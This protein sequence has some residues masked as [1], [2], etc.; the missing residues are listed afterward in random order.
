MAR[1][2]LWLAAFAALATAPG[3][4]TELPAREQ[5]AEPAPARHIA[6]VRFNADECG[7]VS[8]A[9]TWVGPV[10]EVAA[11]QYAELRADGSGVETRAYPL[12]YAPRID[13]FTR[14]VAGVIVSLRGV[15]PARARPWDK[16]PVEVA[17]R[18]ARIEVRQDGVA[19]RT[20]FVRCGD[21]VTMWSAEPRFNALRARGAAYFSLAFPDPDQPLTRTFET[22]GRVALTSAAG[23]YWQAADLFVCDHPYYTA[24]ADGGVYQFRGVPVGEYKLVAWHPN[25][26]AE[27]SERNPETSQPS[28][29]VYAPPLEIVRTISVVRGRNTLANLTLPR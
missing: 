4:G 12:A 9:V 26:V 20:G 21:A 16:S 14:G 28:R 6:P 22:C 10:P 15:D 2:L 17:F 19:G 11:A 3:C 23:Y 8:G 1:P 5:P 25:W 24:T 27:R 7:T 13:A 18:D 29:L